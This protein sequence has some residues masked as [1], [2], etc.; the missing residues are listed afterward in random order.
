M[1]TETRKY[2]GIKQPVEVTVFAEYE[3]LMLCK[4]GK[5]QKFS[6]RGL[7]IATSKHGVLVCWVDG[8][9]WRSDPPQSKREVV[10]QFL[11]IAEKYNNEFAGSYD[12]IRNYWRG[13]PG[14]PEVLNAMRTL[15]VEYA[16]THM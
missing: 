3:N 1:K 10:K 16:K 12:D 11:E 15:S 13:K 2:E 5:G 14:L 9:E 4:V 8:M 7:Q 6:R